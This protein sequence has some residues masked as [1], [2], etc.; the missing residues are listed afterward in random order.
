MNVRKL[1]T[2]IASGMLAITVSFV[3]FTE[4]LP[5][6]TNHQIVI[7]G[8]E[9]VPSELTVSVGDTVTWVNKDIVPHNIAINTKQKPL[10]FN[11]ASGEEFTHKV[12]VSLDYICGL[13]PSMKGKLIINQQ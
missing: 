5:K 4:P 12:S 8:F 2:V 7:S 3:S 6:N 10:S 9:F 11:L 13:H 1:F